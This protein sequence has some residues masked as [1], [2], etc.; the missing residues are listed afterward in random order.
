MIIHNSWTRR[1]WN[2]A[3]VQHYAFF[4]A[5][6]KL[7]LMVPTVLTVHERQLPMPCAKQPSSMHWSSQAGSSF[8]IYAFLRMATFFVLVFCISKYF[9]SWHFYTFYF[10][11][12]MAREVILIL[13]DKTLNTISG[14]IVLEKWHSYQRDQTDEKNFL[15]NSKVTSV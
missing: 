1:A 6:C 13:H 14:Y 2:V 7:G 11:P 3:V 10:P 5:S 12:N 9:I 15:C 4:N 8:N